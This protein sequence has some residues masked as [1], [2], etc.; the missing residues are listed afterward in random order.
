MYN[1]ARINPARD[2]CAPPYGIGVAEYNCPA[3][4]EYLDESFTYITHLKVF[5][6]Q[7]VGVSHWGQRTDVQYFE[8]HDVE[9]GIAMLAQRGHLAHA[10]MQCRSGATLVSSVDGTS[11]VDYQFLGNG[12]E[13]YDTGQVRIVRMS[14]PY[15]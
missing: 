13:W 6:S 9:L 11:N 5:L 15:D 2:T 3:A 4:Y 1:A 10:L 14:H 7:G 12:F 8:A